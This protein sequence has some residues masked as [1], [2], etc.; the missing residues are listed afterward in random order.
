MKDKKY[1]KVRDHCHYTGEY[2]DAPHSICNLKYSLLKKIPIAV[3]NKSNYHYH[4][5]IKQLAEQFEEQFTCLGEN[6]GKY[7]TF[8]I[9]I[10]K[11]FTRIEKQLQKIYPK[12]YNLLI[13]QDLWQV[14]YQI[15]LI[16]I[17][18]EFIKLNVKTDTIIKNVKYEK[19]NKG[20]ATFFL[21]I[22]T[23]KM[24]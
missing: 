17:L 6:T 4:F 3:H 9:L 16:I 23:L 13:A 11:K 1:R 12:Y 7:I 20:I 10:E 8:T 5:I 21:N 15:L 2:R 18:E 22:Q 24:T 14:H 19:L